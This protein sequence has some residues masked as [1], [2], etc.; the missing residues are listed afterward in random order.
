MKKNLFGLIITF[1][2]LSV[3]VLTKEMYNESHVVTNLGGAFTSAPVFVNGSTQVKG[4]KVTNAVVTQLGISDS[5]FY[6]KGSDGKE[7]IV[8]LGDYITR[9]IS[10]GG[11][12]A[13]SKKEFESKFSSKDGTVTFDPNEVLRLAPVDFTKVDEEVDTKRQ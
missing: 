11:I 6:I 10:G 1:I 7:T 2:F 9:G 5:P 4:I 13:I 12:S 3:N 8:R